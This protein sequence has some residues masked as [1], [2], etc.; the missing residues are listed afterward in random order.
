MLATLKAL[1]DPTR[2]R[3]IALLS[4]GEL[5]VQ[6][7]TVVLG[8]GQSRISRHLKI[9]VGAGILSVKRQGTWGYYRVNG[10][11]GLF[12]EIW[13]SLQRRQAGLPEHRRDMAELARLL[14]EQRNR[15][16]RFFDQHARDWDELAGKILPVADYRN[17]LVAMVEPGRVVLEVGVG[18]GALLAA[19]A[20]RAG[21]LIGVDHSPAML[22]EAR[23]RLA[24]AG[25]ASIDLRLG[26]MDHLPL[27]D[28]EVDVV[29]L[30][31]VFHHALQPQTVLC[32]LNRVLAPG[33]RLLVADL[34][35]HELEWVRERLADQWLGFEQKELQGWLSATGF[36]VQ[37]YQ[38]L[39]GQ[40]GEQGAFILSAA[41]AAAAVD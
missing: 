41:R 29:L 16:Q 21:R 30:N 33:G 22:R 19:L 6:D 18:S 15:S 25:L 31:M 39:V 37:D 11:E 36:T 34:Q 20:S 24:G 26:E 7:L 32:E 8:M 14:E 23:E 5:T 28:G 3:L 40:P 10:A 27:S 1:A 2:M 35:R 13:P 17:Q 4:Q 9:L 12:G 38:A